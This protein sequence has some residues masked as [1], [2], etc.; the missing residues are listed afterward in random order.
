MYKGRG[1]K[2]DQNEEYHSK[3]DAENQIAVEGIWRKK[4]K[5]RKSKAGNKQTYFCKLVPKRSTEQCDAKLFLLCPHEG[6]S[7][8]IYRTSRSLQIE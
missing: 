5:L 8:Y 1:V 4:D 3:E 7:V 6:S 2:Y